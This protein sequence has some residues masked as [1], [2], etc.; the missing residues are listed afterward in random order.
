MKRLGF[1]FFLIFERLL[2]VLPFA[3]LYKIADFVYF[4][5]Y[6]VIK[7]RKDVIYTNLK[8]AFPLKSEAEID[9]LRKKYTKIMAD[10]IIES[11]KAPYLSKKSILSRFTFNNID[12]LDHLYCKNKSLF[13][14]CGH[15]GSW[16]LAGMIFPLIT[17][18]KIYGIYQ[19]QSN[20]YFDKHIKKIRSTFGLYPVTSQ[21]A[22][23]TFIREK[24]NLILSIIVADQAPPK[25][26]DHYWTNFLN[27]ETAFFTGLEKMSKS[28]DYAVVFLSIIR[29]D[30]GKYSLDFELLTETPKLTTYGEISEMYV[31]SL[32]N[33][34]N[35]YPE[36]WL[37]SHRRWKHKR[38]LN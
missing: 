21:Q 2:A 7:Y 36:N 3:V 17:K 12:I 23:K 14:V 28:L 6:Y 13:V 19:P 26:G 4:L 29:T 30:R 35:Q 22:Y 1:I 8:N 10:L 18:Y 24:E 5:L 37:W 34:I 31:R 33:L 16:E 27:Q 38:N 9:Q 25:N 15:T 11:L 32:E 20:P